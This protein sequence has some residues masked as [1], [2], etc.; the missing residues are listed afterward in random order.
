LNHIPG[1]KTYV[2]LRIPRQKIPHVTRNP[3]F[4]ILE[5]LFSMILRSFAD[6]ES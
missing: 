6:D 5:T 2:M 4:D 1:S 3:D